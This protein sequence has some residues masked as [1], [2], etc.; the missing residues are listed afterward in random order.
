MRLSENAY[1]VLQMRYLAPDETPEQRFRAVARHVAQ[2]EKSWAPV[3]SW[4]KI[5]QEYEDKFFN[6]MS[7]LKFLPNSPTIGNAGKKNAQ[8]SACFVLPVDDDMEGIFGTLKDT[9]LIHK[10]GGG[11]GFAFSRLRPRGDHVETT[12]GVASGPVSFMRVYDA[13][14]ES[15][16]QCGSRRGANMG[17]LRVDH[18]DILEFIHCKSDMV[19]CQNFNISVA[20]TDAFMEALLHNEEYELRN[21]RTG[22]VVSTLA[23]STVWSAILTNAW[24]NGDPGLFFI[25]AANRDNPTSHLGLYEATNPC[26]E[27]PLLPY[28]SCN[29]GSINLSKFYSKLTMN[30]DWSELQKAIYLA[31]RFL[32]DVIEVNQYPVKELDRMARRTRKIGL[33]VMG[34]ADLLYKLGIPYNSKDAVNLADELYRFFRE[35]ADLASIELAM[36][37]GVYP[38]WLS[39]NHRGVRYRNACRTTVAPT[40]TLS[41]LADC[42]GGIEPVFALSFKRQHRLDRNNPLGVTVMYE[43]NQV[44]KDALKFCDVDETLI[45]EQLAEGASLH[46]LDVPAGIKKIFVTA[47][48]I[49]P[50]WHVK[51][52]AAFQKHTDA[53]VSKTV[54][55]QHE[56]TIEDIEQVYLTAWY[57]GCK[58]VTIYRDGS[59]ELQVLSTPKTKVAA[60]V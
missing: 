14:T 26:G 44:F 56:A 35:Q 27:Q 29:L 13:A 30:I 8:L 28:E 22:A 11:T 59:R 20:I 49:T 53:A 37:R 55:F 58:G 47:H 9:A 46:D 16:K 33:G 17:I 52:Q 50:E 12:G 10:S 5:V 38:A 25:D 24:R 60:T 32:D 19:T 7:E 4:E 34:W 54:N 18:P 23:A 3:F 31:V 6:L 57:E 40:G 48:D 39:E 43:T 2:A 51:M 21:P 41:I 15:V 1:R 42:S 36:I 45:V